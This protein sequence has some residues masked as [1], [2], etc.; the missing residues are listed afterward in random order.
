[1]TKACPSVIKTCPPVSKASPPVTKASPPVSEGGAQVTCTSAR[2]SFEDA[3]FKELYALNLKLYRYGICNIL[4]ENKF[5]KI[6]RGI[7]ESG[8]WAIIH[9]FTHSPCRRFN[10]FVLQS[11]FLSV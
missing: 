9:R 4:M 5:A 7:G 6:L 2:I 11:H 3:L 10:A 8:E 1:M